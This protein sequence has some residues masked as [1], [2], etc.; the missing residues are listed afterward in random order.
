M[1]L[2]IA[3]VVLVSWQIN[4]SQQQIQEFDG[5]DYPKPT[6]S[7]LDPSTV[8]TTVPFLEYITVKQFETR[9]IFSVLKPSTVVSTVISPTT[10]TEISTITSFGTRTDF[11]TIINVATETLPPVTNV[12]TSLVTQWKTIAY[13]V[14]ETEVS[15][16]KVL[17][18]E[19]ET[20]YDTRISTIRHTVTS[21][22][23]VTT[24]VTTTVCSL[25]NA[26]LPALDNPTCAPVNV[27]PRELPPP[28]DLLPP[29]I[30]LLA[31]PANTIRPTTHT[32]IITVTLEPT[33]T[34][35]RIIRPTST[36]VSYL[37][38]T[39]I[40]QTIR[41]TSTKYVSKGATTVTLSFTKTASVIQYDQRVTKTVNITPTM[42]S[43]IYHDAV[44]KT[45]QRRARNASG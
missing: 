42:T 6:C 12:V 5:Y 38:A 11:R 31:A 29:D 24:V 26:Y 22:L 1:K 16:E 20:Q 35:T 32:K 28:L 44:T 27:F 21:T 15:T 45:I 30:P 40:S 34:N 17:L 3:F 23:P 13:P 19:T 4:F 33:E 10:T 41:P 36:V 8:T 14:V 2:M 7:L 18:T 43:Y 37:D 39:T 9:T 25:N